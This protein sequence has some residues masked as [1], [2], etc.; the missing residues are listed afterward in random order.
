[1]KRR[2][3]H[4]SRSIA[5]GIWEEEEEEEEASYRIEYL[6]RHRIEKEGWDADAARFV[7]GGGKD[8]LATG[9]YSWG[10]LNGRYIGS[11]YIGGTPRKWRGKK[12]KE[13]VTVDVTNRSSLK[14]VCASVERINLLKS[15]FTSLFAS[16]TFF[17]IRLFFYIFYFTSTN[18][19]WIF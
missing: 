17:F 8:G 10:V 7:L 3:R 18:V 14:K 19:K 4:R 12:K 15:L 11:I 13:R 6:W 2:G 9:G 5:Q 1:M 16:Q